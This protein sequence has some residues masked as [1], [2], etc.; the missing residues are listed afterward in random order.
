MPDRAFIY[1]RDGQWRWTRKAPNHETVAAS[2]EGYDR[3]ADA[4]ANYERVSGP[5]SP[6]L[7]PLNDDDEPST[8]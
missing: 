3:K 5:N 8:G 6:L 1:I 7:E 4:I 2:T